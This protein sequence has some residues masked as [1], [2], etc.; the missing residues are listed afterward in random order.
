MKCISL[1]L[2]L[3]VVTSTA[4]QKPLD[5][6]IHKRKTG[7]VSFLFGSNTEAEGHA[8]ANA[9][10]HVVAL[11]HLPPATLPLPTCT[12]QLLVE[13]DQVAL[14]EKA[15]ATGPIAR[16]GQRMSFLKSGCVQ[17]VAGPAMEKRLFR[18]A[19]PSISSPEEKGGSFDWVS[20]AA[21]LFSTLGLVAY[22]FFMGWWGGY[23]KVADTLGLWFL[24]LG[25]L[26]GFLGIRRTKRGKRRGGSLALVSFIVGA[27]LPST[28]IIVLIAL[29]T[30]NFS[31]PF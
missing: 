10:G 18:R 28:A 5:R 14:L 13:P 6:G 1:F 4:A 15:K 23:L 20:L 24:S 9:F 11:K 25:F 21:M 8:E 7:G 16:V 2:S 31:I 27:I 29:L 22:G 19:I 12:R 17:A 3:I 30:G 26:L